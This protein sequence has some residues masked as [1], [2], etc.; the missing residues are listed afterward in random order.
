MPANTERSP[1]PGALRAAEVKALRDALVRIEREADG[2]EEA[3]ALARIQTIGAI[4][5]YALAGEGES[6]E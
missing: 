6:N 1:S 2:C 5:H 3:W 4:A